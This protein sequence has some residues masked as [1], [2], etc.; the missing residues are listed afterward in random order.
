[1]KK[2]SLRPYPGNLYFCKTKTSYEK[3][4]K[5][6]FGNIDNLSQNQ[7]GRFYG[8]ED[9]NGNWT[10]IIWGRNY[11]YIVHEICHVVLHLFSRIGINP[12]ESAAGESFCYL[13]SQLITD[14]KNIKR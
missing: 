12:V 5:K 13:V 9:D 14:I 11:E 7:F 10:Y 1:M 3:G 8:S 4:Y 2:L 6:L